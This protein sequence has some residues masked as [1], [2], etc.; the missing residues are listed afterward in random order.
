[1]LAGLDGASVSLVE[2]GWNAS[3]ASLVV[4]CLYDKDFEADFCA[5]AGFE[6]GS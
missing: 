6:E 2:L 1:M 3:I 5:T 4:A